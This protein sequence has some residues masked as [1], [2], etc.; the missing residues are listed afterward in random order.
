M[1]ALL[2]SLLPLSLSAGMLISPPT[3]TPENGN[4]RWNYTV[5]IEGSTLEPRKAGTFLDP[6]IDV[7]QGWSFDLPDGYVV[8]S[9]RVEDLLEPYRVELPPPH[10]VR[11]F[12]LPE[13]V[14][15]HYEVDDVFVASETPTRLRFDYGY[16]PRLDAPREGIYVAA[17]LSFLS[18]VG[19]AQVAQDSFEWD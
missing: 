14:F 12:P 13:T 4:F 15:D 7:D 8:G 18:S 17:R 5:S 9:V 16:G 1:K 19:T 11:T 3:I 10:M 6:S 2:L